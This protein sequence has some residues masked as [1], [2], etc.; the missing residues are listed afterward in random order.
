[1]DM[2]WHWERKL[3][4]FSI[5]L[6]KFGQM[7]IKRRANEKTKWEQDRQCTHKGGYTLVTLPHTITLYRDSVDG[8]RD[9]VTY[10]KLVT[11]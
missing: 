1:M 2:W 3:C 7:F 4:N 5:Q 8:T 11:R 10:K 6:K 9:H